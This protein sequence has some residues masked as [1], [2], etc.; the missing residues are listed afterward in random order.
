MAAPNP[1][2]QILYD[3]CRIWH[4]EMELVLYPERFRS[5]VHA[6]DRGMIFRELR[7][8]GLSV[9]RICELTPLSRRSV[10]AALNGNGTV[11]A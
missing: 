5:Q 8:A 11:K 9:S 1:D 3:V 10:E 7:K 2:Y 4:A 6:R